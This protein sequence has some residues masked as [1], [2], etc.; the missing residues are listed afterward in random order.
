MIPESGRPFLPGP[1]RA[2]RPWATYRQAGGGPDMIKI[3]KIALVLAA[4]GCA[5]GGSAE[6]APAGVSGSGVNGF[7]AA[8]AFAQAPVRRPRPRARITVRPPIYPYRTISTP[9]PTPYPI[10]YPGRGAVRQCEARL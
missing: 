1:L 4:V 10:E 2:L 6:A 5:A 8:K 9:Y 3:L 7:H